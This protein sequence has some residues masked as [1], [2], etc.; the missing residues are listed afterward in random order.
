MDGFMLDS[1]NGDIQINKLSA[2]NSELLYLQILEN[3]RS[4]ILTGYL[5]EGEFLPSERELA[6]MFDVSRMPVTLALKI[7]EF[8]GVIA[9][10]RGKGFCI[11][12]I[13]IPHI[14]RCIGFLAMSPETVEDD[15]LDARIAIEPQT[16]ELAALKHTSDDL[17]AM[18]AALHDMERRIENANGESDVEQIEMASLRF[19]SAIVA[20]SR[21]EIL[22]KV[23][24]F[25]REILMISRKKTLCNKELQSN[26]LEKH[27]AILAA[28]KARDAQTAGRL[29]R[30]HLQEGTRTVAG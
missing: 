13:D 22:I 12:K 27:R 2:S 20:A 29:M 17:A 23:N 6:A 18:E 16:A 11:K 21:N 1:R 5:K 14:V 25:L 7:L 26:S 24:D 15:I 10:V 30:E 28:V 3:I 8:L 9:F 19:H 4:W